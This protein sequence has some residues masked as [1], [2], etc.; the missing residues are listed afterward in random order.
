MYSVVPDASIRVTSNIRAMAERRLRG[1]ILYT[2]FGIDIVVRKG[3]DV[4]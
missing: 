3:A 1:F 2:C 4:R